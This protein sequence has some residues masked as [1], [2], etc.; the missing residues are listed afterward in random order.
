MRPGINVAYD[1]SKTGCSFFAIKEVYCKLFKVCAVLGVLRQFV[2][3][4]EG[5]A[6][7]VQLPKV[8]DN[9]N[10]NIFFIK[11]KT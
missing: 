1:N 10:N 2:L 8:E 7:Y 11:L 6:I 3:R 4:D 9:A 5:G